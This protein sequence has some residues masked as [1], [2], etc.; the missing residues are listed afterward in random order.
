MDK[1][2]SVTL[3]AALA[4][5]AGCE[6]KDSSPD[7]ICGVSNLCAND[8]T[9]F[10]FVDSA[11]AISDVCAGTM[12]ATAVPPAGGSTV[13]TLTHPEKGTLCIAGELSPSGFALIALGLMKFNADGTEIVGS[14]D[15]TAKGIVAVAITIDTPPAQGVWFDAHNVVKTSCPDTPLDCF[16]PPNFNFMKVTAPGRFVAPLAQFISEDDPNQSVDASALAEVFFQVQDAGP[17]DFC[18]H[19]LAFLDGAGNPVTP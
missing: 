1:I 13:P 4:W 9:A 5:G 6:S 14:L 2:I 16:Y 18:V 11:I 19:D 10:P 15:A 3:V 12:C 8:L 17:Y 7:R